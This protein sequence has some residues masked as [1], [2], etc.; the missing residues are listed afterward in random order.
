[1]MLAG[2][3]LLTPEAHADKFKKLQDYERDHYEA[4]RVYFKDEKKETKI[5]LKLKTP[6][7]R[8]QWLKD[9]G[10]WDKFYKYDKFERE[11]IVAKEPKLGWSQDMVYMA[12]GPPYTK[13][14][15]TKR[16]AGDTRIL[17]YRME[18]TKD[19]EHMVWAPKSKETY[20]AIKRY[21]TY[22]T[23]DDYTITDIREEDGWK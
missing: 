8:D 15:S 1:M 2:L 12:W 23:L 19:G 17:V 11:A 5:W 21:T 22:L 6:A 14:K 10:Y 20:K 3:L 13:V 4:L 18:V 16:T 7:E 9:A